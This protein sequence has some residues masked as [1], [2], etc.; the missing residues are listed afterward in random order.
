MKFFKN[1]KERLILVHKKQVKKSQFYLPFYHLTFPKIF[2]SIQT[3]IFCINYF[4]I[5]NNIKNVIINIGS[6]PI[7]FLFVYILCFALHNIF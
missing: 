1:K 2:S 7:V 4:Y 6:T 3:N 5:E